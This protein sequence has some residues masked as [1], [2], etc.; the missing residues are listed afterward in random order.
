MAAI[1]EGGLIATNPPYGVRVGKGG[2]VRDL[3]AQLG[4]VV[5]E[6]AHGASIAMYLP[7]PHLGRQTRLPLRPLYKTANGGLPVAA[8]LA[9]VS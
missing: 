4:H 7:D 3:F 9:S 6:K 2:D 5:R 8:V 1:A